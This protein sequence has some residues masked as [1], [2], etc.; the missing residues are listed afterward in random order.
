[1]I[2]QER[3]PWV[4]AAAFPKSLTFLPSMQNGCFACTTFCPTLCAQFVHLLWSFIFLSKILLVGSLP[5]CNIRRS[6]ATEQVPS[7]WW[8]RMHAPF[9]A[10]P[11]VDPN[12]MVWLKGV[13][14]CSHASPH[15]NRKMHQDRV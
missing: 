5:L 12:A 4:N 14:G 2:A 11:W 15:A 10:P 6:D 7:Q 3:F 13:P 8:E 1:M 9:L